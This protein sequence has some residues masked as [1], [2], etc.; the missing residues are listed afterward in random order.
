M[1]ADV[2]E[3]KAKNIRVAIFD[4]DG[5]LTNGVIALNE[6]GEQQRF[7]HVHD[8]VGLKLLQSAG[9]EV[10]II[11]TTP[12][13]KIKIRLEQ[14]AIHHY[15]CG[16]K[17]KMAD[18]ETLKQRL[19]VSDS[20]CAYMGDDLPDLPILEKVG[21]S[22][23]VSNGLPRLKECVDFISHLPGGKGAVRTFTDFILQAQALED[24]A[25]QAYLGL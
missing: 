21:L 8:G 24:K 11:T 23:T 16:N 3:I 14:L 2:L 5:V 4:L 12:Y 1:T 6:A 7:Y 9:I 18:Y 22:A 10:A 20:Q 13:D 25:T 19:N 17:Q 15:F